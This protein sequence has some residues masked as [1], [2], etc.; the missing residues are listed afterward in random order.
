MNRTRIRILALAAALAAAPSLAGCA[1]CRDG[2]I[3]S[4]NCLAQGG[5]LGPNYKAPLAVIENAAWLP[6]RAVAT[7]LTGIVQGGVGWY[8]ECGEPVSATLTLPVGVALGAIYGT[9]NSF[10]QNPVLIERDDNFWEALQ[11][12]YITDQEIYKY[13]TPPHGR[14]FYGPHAPMAEVMDDPETAARV[15]PYGFAKS[16]NYDR[17]ENRIE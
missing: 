11:A 7:P 10:G 15:A 1:T 5:G 6:Y 2:D 14:P 17:L 12:P 3:G 13:T 8:E 9:I 16:Y 4:K